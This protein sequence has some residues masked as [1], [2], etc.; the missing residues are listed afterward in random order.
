MLYGLCAKPKSLTSGS[1]TGATFVL[2]ANWAQAAYGNHTLTQCYTANK[3]ADFIR[4]SDSTTLTAGFVNQSPDVS[5]LQQFMSGTTATWSKLYDQSG[6]A[7][8][9]TAGSDSPVC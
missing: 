3:W 4:A 1:G 7:H 5:S 9:A 6:Y 2:T 8:D